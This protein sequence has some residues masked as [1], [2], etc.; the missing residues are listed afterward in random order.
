MAGSRGPPPG[1]RGA[2]GARPGDSDRR[3][4]GAQR[5]GPPLRRLRGL[6]GHPEVEPVDLFCG[7]GG[8]ACRCPGCTVICKIW[9][10][11][12]RK[13]TRLELQSLM[14]ISYA[15]FCLKKKNKTE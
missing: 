4:D 8:Y 7:R 1:W 6:R 2:A 13:S 5:P 9:H 14:R 15:V 3:G 10:T 12:D 11:G